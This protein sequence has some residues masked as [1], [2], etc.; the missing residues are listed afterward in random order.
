MA[1]EY[2]PGDTCLA[3]A[4]APSGVALAALEAIGG[5]IARNEHAARLHNKHD[6]AHLPNWYPG[7]EE[8]GA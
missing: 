7:R 5:G 6:P 3:C 4:F 8:N 1:P 2:V